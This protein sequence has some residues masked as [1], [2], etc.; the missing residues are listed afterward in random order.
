MKKSL[1][2]SVF[3]GFLSLSSAFGAAFDEEG[4][5]D[6]LT[7]MREFSESLRVSL[8]ESFAS[9]FVSASA[10]IESASTSA[11]ASI[12]S[13]EETLFADTPPPP[14][15]PVDVAGSK[16]YDI[17]A[18]ESAQEPVN[19]FYCPMGIVQTLALLRAVMVDKRALEEI[20]TFVES[21]E[22]VEYI[23]RVN[24]ALVSAPLQLFSQSEEEG[25]KYVFS[26]NV[27][28]ILA[29]KLPIKRAECDPI[30]ESMGGKIVPLDFSNPQQSAQEINAI[31]QKDTRDNIR[32]LANEE[33]FN[34]DQD[35]AFVLLHTL[36]LNASW[37]FWAAEKMVHFHNLSGKINRV[38]AFKFRKE[39]FRLIESEGC[40]LV[41]VPT[42]QGCFVTIRC[43]RDL[44]AVTEND[45]NALSRKKPTHLDG[46]K[47]PCVKMR[48]KLPLKEL[49]G[50]HF[51]QTFSE[52]LWSR[53]MD[54]YPITIDDF[55][56]E[57]TFDMSEK[58]V[59][60]S[61]ATMM[62]GLRQMCAHMKPPQKKI[63]I[64]KPFTLTLSKEIEQGVH[65]IL[66]QGQ[67]VSK[68]AM[69]L[70]EPEPLFY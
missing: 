59:E 3:C 47:I 24:K 37:K 10:T 21:K 49:L 61:S 1:L 67:V 26:N 23:T 30:F 40:V 14:P 9:S 62:V 20:E 19:A 16:L 2:A 66:V 6:L 60:T 13:I 55:Q 5:A 53:L 57:V 63:C 28:A 7:K 52:E 38:K 68:E 8:A 18:Q 32:D 45:L 27:Y 17:L 15:S 42:V 35:T 70:W 48:K 33:M 44:R 41:M 58:G 25:K 29:Q 65:C 12:A 50:K 22:L 43:G 4:L 39:S 64:D 54:D 34:Q 46:L 11:S 51:S 69:T 36:Y 56:Q 31:I